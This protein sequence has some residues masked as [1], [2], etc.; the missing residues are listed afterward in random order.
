[1]ENTTTTEAPAA[2]LTGETIETI[3]DT[4][5]AIWITIY[6]LG[7]DQKDHGCVNAHGSR[8]WKSGGYYQG[9]HYKLRAEV[10][11]QPNDCGGSNRWDTETTFACTAS[12]HFVLKEANDGSFYWQKM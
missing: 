5:Y 1:M 6:G 12:N 2:R 4:N 9:S 8:D 11:N 10:K 7:N 3:N